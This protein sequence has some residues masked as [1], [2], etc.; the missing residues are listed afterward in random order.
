MQQASK[1]VPPVNQ[2][3]FPSGNTSGSGATS[4]GSIPDP[5]INKK[6]AKSNLDTFFSFLFGDD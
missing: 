4:G 6:N 3:S 1:E 2:G 5:N